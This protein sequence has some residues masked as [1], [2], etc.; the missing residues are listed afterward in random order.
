MD[1]NT[2]IG[3]LANDWFEKY[4]VDENDGEFITIEEN[5]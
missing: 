4:P 1:F 5:D 2:K 3:Q